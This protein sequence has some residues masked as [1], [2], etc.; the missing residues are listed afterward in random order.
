M[1]NNTDYKFISLTNHLLLT[2][3]FQKVDFREIASIYEA[4]F[5]SD[6]SSLSVKKPT[7]VT[8]VSDFIPQIISFIEA[9]LKDN[10]AYKTDDGSVYFNLSV[11]SENYKYGKLKAV[12]LEQPSA[13][14]GSYSNSKKNDFALWKAAKS[15]SE[16]GWEPSW[17]G[18]GRPGWH[19]LL[20]YY[21]LLIS[22]SDFYS[23]L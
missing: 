23:S 19:V 7:L 2:S 12:T 8:R 18:R 6:L 11:Y 16:P 1:T 4:D 5:F 21:L 9:L 15:S 13:K 14:N 10:M 22:C 3:N 20:Y 17:G